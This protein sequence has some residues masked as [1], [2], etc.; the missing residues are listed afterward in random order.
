MIFYWNERSYFLYI[1]Y[2]WKSGRV[3]GRVQHQRL[4]FM[5]ENQEQASL[6]YISVKVS[7]HQVALAVL[8]WCPRRK[9][10]FLS[11]LF[12]LIDYGDHQLQ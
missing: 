11:L 4:A 10:I 2:Y 3:H 9:N 7:L 12:K 1:V 8:K 5:E 6:R